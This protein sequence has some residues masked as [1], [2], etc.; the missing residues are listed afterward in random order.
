MNARNFGII[1]RFIRTLLLMV[2]LGSNR[3]R[4][5]HIKASHTSTIWGFYFLRSKFPCLELFRYLEA[6]VFV[7]NLC[8]FSTFFGYLVF[9]LCIMYMYSDNAPF[10]FT[11]FWWPLLFASLPRSFANFVVLLHC[12]VSM[13]FW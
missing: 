13:V 12:S 8:S 2:Q 11:L 6:V 4:M 5:V 3:L 9:L 7:S 1:I 10:N